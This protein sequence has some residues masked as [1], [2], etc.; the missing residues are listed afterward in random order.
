MTAVAAVAVIAMQFDDRRRGVEQI[1]G[2]DKGNR[3]GEARV[4]LRV[5]VGHAMAAT[6]QEIV[7]GEPPSLPQ[8][9]DREIVGQDV[10]RVVLGNREP[11]LELARQITLAVERVGRLPCGSLVLPFLAVDPDF[12]IGAGLRQQMCR[13]PPGVGFEPVVHRIAD[14]RRHRRH[15]AHH[16]A[17][18]G[19]CRQQ[20]PVDLGHRRLQAGFDDA[21]KLDA[22]PRRDPQRPVG[23]VAADRVEAEIL[24]RGQP[25]ARDA[26][27]NHEL[28]DLALTALL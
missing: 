5:V 11:D 16:V 8:R 24:V 23:P 17:A 6:E 12:V 9:H 22:L 28:P 19:Q 21:V 13:E 4:G 26:H 27:P 7:A 15:R 18:G 2:L 10:D 14:R 1:A 3:G 25:P 20:R